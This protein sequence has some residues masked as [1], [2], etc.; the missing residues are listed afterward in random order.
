[1]WQLNAGT[2]KCQKRV[3][4]SLVLD[5]LV[6]AICLIWVVELNLGCLQEPSG[7]CFVYYFNEAVNLL[8]F[9]NNKWNYD[10]GSRPHTYYVVIF[11]DM[12]NHSFCLDLHVSP[13]TYDWL[14]PINLT[15]AS[16]PQRGI[17]LS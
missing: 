8:G 1:M 7:Q 10:R 9:R 15:T 2:C 13:T 3:L 5:I 4:D 17:H 11:Y 6:V 16:C 12:K 14:K